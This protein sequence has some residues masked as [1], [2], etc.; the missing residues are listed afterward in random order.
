MQFLF[1]Q[2]LLDTLYV[3]ISNYYQLE[4]KKAI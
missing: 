4:I 3:H 1:E 2:L